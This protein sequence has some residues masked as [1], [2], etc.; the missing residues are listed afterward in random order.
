MC[1]MF[2][3]EHI[4]STFLLFAIFPIV[5]IAKINP[6]ALI[7]WGE[8]KILQMNQIGGVQWSL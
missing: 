4:N 6:Y 8:M 3:I 1:N 2:R 7:Y 5:N